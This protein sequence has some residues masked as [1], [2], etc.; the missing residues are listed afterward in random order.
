MKGARAAVAKGSA[1]SAQQ[2]SVRK[3]NEGTSPQPCMRRVP[4]LARAPPPLQ[5]LLYSNRAFARCCLADLNAQYGEN[6][7]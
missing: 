7:T 4:L 5:K 3:Q 6:G 2:E 1:S